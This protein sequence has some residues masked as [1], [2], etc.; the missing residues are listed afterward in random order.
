MIWRDSLLQLV[1]RQAGQPLARD[2]PVDNAQS[3]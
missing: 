3:P 1:E 2:A